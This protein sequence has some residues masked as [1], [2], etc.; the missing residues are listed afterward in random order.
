[1][2]LDGNLLYPSGREAHL[3][4]LSLRAAAVEEDC[5][6]CGQQDWKSLSIMSPSQVLISSSI[7]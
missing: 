7:K 4:L 2:P 1:M 6:G 3:E 5:Q